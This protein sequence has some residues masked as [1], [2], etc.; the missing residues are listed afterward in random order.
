VHDVLDEGEN[1][2]AKDAGRDGR[3]TEASEDGS[4]SRSLVPSPLHVASA[5]C[6]NTNTSDGRDKRVGRRNVGRVAGTPHNPDGGTSRCASECEKL[7]G[8]VAVECRDRDNAVLDGRCSPSTDCEGTSDFE[9]QTEDHSLLVCDGTGGNTRG[10]CVCDIVCEEWLEGLIER[11]IDM[12]R[13][14]R[15]GTVVV[16]LKQGEE[17]A[18]GKDVSVFRKHLHGMSTQ[19]RCVSLE[20]VGFIGGVLTERAEGGD[21]TS[22]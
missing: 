16:R 2:R 10:P 3:H 17:G 15:T 22:G 14:R 20:M 8:S 1:N 4:E 12:C 13:E 21:R 18:D 19:K 7:N 6:S 9:D 5:D 11:V